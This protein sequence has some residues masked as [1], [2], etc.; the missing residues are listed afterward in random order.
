MKCE[1]PVFRGE[2][3]DSVN[4]RN[5]DNNTCMLLETQ[6]PTL[7]LELELELELELCSQRKFRCNCC[8]PVCFPEMTGTSPVCM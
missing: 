3:S 8:L 1:A 7:N 2:Q 6:Q 5:P 4:R